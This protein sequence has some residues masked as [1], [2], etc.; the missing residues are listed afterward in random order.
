MEAISANRV[1]EIFMDCLYRDG[2]DTSDHVK[3]EGI[4]ST[5]GFHPQRLQG[6]AAEIQETLLM[7]P[8]EFHQDKGGGMSFLNACMDR[9]GNHWAEHPT[10]EMLFQLGI[11]TGKAKCLMPREMWR[12][13]PGGMPY[14]AV[15]TAA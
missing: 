5:A 13:M 14:Y 12:V 2:E 1:R 3:A 6:H 8:D 11:A 15:L 4:M 7:L 10:I 9:N